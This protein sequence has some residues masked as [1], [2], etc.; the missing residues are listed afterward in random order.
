MLD[1][2][3][4]DA[5]GITV[6]DLQGCLVTGLGLE[7]LRPRIQQLVDAKRV[8]VVLNASGVSTIDSSGVGELVASFSSLKRNGGS[9]KIATPS[10]FVREVLQITRL[11]TIIEVHE[12][13]EA[14]LAAFEK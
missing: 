10:K 8:N 13:V 2:K 11:P 9:L 14:A 3:T 1:I 12:T 4:R 7:S 6:L 5:G